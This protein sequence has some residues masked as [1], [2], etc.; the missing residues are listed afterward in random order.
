MPRKPCQLREELSRLVEK[1]FHQAVA[2]QLN[3]LL[4]DGCWLVV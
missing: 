2:L 3:N 1:E 4:M